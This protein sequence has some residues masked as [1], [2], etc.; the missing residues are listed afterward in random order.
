M[1]SKTFQEVSMKFGSFFFFTLALTAVLLLACGS[2]NNSHVPQSVSV[3]PATANAQDFPSGQVPFTATAYY[4]TMPSPIT[5][6]TATWGA[7]Y[8]NIPTD[9]VS[10]AT[11]GL[12][13]CMSGATGTYTIYAFVA[14]PEFKGTCGSGAA[15]CGGTCGGVVGS[16]Q[17][18]CP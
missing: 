3:T 17:L 6:A 9:A 16:A 10:V 18:T 15:P 8:Q 11:T 14:N 2:S 5:P 12:A 7:C 4:N 1:G 13:Q